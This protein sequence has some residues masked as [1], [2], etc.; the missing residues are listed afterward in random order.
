MITVDTAGPPRQVHRGQLPDQ[1]A[2][3]TDRG[4]MQTMLEDTHLNTGLATGKCNDLQVKVEG[5]NTLDTASHS[6]L[7]EPVPPATLPSSATATSLLDKLLARTRTVQQKLD[8][9]TNP[10]AKGAMAEEA[11][12]DRSPSTPAERPGALLDGCL[13]QAQTLLNKVDKLSAGYARTSHATCG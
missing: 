5:Y 9:M 11:G 8:M 3:I 13:S 10:P 12:V 1:V 4:H 7:E 6:P 2:N